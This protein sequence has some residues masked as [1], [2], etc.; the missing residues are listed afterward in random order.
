[1]PKKEEGIPLE[2]DLSKLKSLC[3]SYQKLYKATERAAIKVEYHTQELTKARDKFQFQSKQEEEL[4][5]DVME[6]V[7]ACIARGLG[8]EARAILSATIGSITTEG[9]TWNE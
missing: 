5:A 7:N 3:A 8:D 2:G 6:E 9:H 4:E 1:M